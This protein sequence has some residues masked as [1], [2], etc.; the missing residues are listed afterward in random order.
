MVHLL[1]HLVREIKFYGPVYLRWMYPIERYMNILKGYVKNQ[2]RP[3]ASMIERYIAEE[4]VEFCSNYMAKAKPIGVPQRSWL[5]KCSI[6]NNIRGLSVVSKD[7]K[8][9]KELMQAHLYILNNADEVMPYLSAHKVI[10]KE[11]NLRQSQKWH[12]MEHNRTFMPWFKSEIL[13]ASQCS[14]TLMWLANGWNLMSSIVQVMKSIIT[15]FIR[16]L[17]MIKAQYKIVESV[18]KLSRYNFLHLK[19]KILYLDQ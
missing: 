2:Y 14:E 17:W 16:S 11:N 19:I 6:S 3:E 4:S 8:D 12:L 13:K 7:R 5:N 9:R 1:V 18:L 15:H 10:V